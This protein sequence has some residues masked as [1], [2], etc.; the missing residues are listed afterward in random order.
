MDLP[1]LMIESL[2]PRGSPWLV[3]RN[4]ILECDMELIDK[5]ALVTG[6]TMGIGAAICEELCAVGAG[7]SIVARYDGQEAR[8]VHQ[9]VEQL[10]QRCAVITADLRNA[11]SCQ[12]AVQKTIEHFG[13]LDILIHNAGGPS[14]GTID[15]VDPEQWLA[16][17][18]LHVNAN[19]FL[20]R[21]ALPH[22]RRNLR[23]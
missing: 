9:C 21:A 11:D 14:P 12:A 20:C 16:T 1:R 3:P 18:D 22:L 17:M 7:I 6:G 2:S 5:V 15:E 23:G 10:G 8:R 19:Y 4:L 13:R